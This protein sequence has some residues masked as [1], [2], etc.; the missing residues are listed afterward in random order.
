MHKYIPLLLSLLVSTAGTGCQTGDN[1]VQASLDREFSLAIGQT[2]AL[3]GEQLTVRFDEIRS[4]SRCPRGAMC[5]WQGEVSA[6]LRVSDGGAYSQIVLTGPGGQG[7]KATYKQFEFSSHVEPYPE[8]G[9]KI[10]SEDYRL[11]LTVRRTT[12]GK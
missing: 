4:D 7:G 5:I 6:V 11:L 8:V 9:K 10:A 2:A 1:T 3:Q 12:S